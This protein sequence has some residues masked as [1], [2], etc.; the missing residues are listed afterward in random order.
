MVPELRPGGSA[1]AGLPVP[2]VR[3]LRRPRRAFSRGEGSG[4]LSPGLGPELGALLP[5][6]FWLGGLPYEN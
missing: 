5:F 1:G 3:G 6:L 4:G 2:A